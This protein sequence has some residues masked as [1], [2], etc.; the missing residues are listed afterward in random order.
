VLQV[1]QRCQEALEEE[2]QGKTPLPAEEKKQSSPETNVF[3]HPTATVDE[4]A[5]I[6]QGSRVWHYC[7]IMPEARIGKNC[8]IGQNVYVARGVQVGDNVKLQNN[9]SLFEGVTLEDGVFCGP[10]M[11]FTNVIN[12]RSE[13]ERKNEYKP[14]LA[15]R[16]STFGANCTIVCGST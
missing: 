10:S 11:V 16:G 12:P 5:E 3:V 15:K 7:H 13:I 8:S 9:V 6:G 4:G 1:L 14:T 2:R